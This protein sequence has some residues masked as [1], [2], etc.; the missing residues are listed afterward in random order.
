MITANWA[1]Y[2]LS[3]QTESGWRG[4]DLQRTCKEFGIHVL[5]L[6]RYFF[7][8]E[9]ISISAKMPKG[10]NPSGP[11]YLNL[12]QLEFSGDRVAQ[13][14]LDRLSKGPHRYL[15]MRLDGSKAIVE[16]SIG[17][18]AALNM[19]IRAR[20]KKPYVDLDVSMGGMARLYQGEK[21]KK[22]ASDPLDLF[23]NAT[24]KLVKA[25]IEAIRNNT[26]PPCN[27]ADNRNTL[28][29][30]IAAYESNDT[31]MPVCIRR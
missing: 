20:D 25:F 21:Y 16:T 5:D 29:L 17:G 9:P 19:G 1:N 11:D 31:K 15:D 8:E 22:I 24:H 12:I 18:N 26:T 10:S 23:A 6:C 3:M 28:A 2:Y 27:A 4:G 13:I 30:M 14:T 7:D